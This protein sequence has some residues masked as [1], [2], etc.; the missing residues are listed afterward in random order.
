MI[1][2]F[3]LLKTFNLYSYWHS[4][5]LSS[6]Y[7]STIFRTTFLLIIQNLFIFGYHIFGYL[8]I[9]FVLCPYY[10]GQSNAYTLLNTY[11]EM[12]ERMNH[13]PINSRSLVK[14]DTIFQVRISIWSMVSIQ[15]FV[16][17][18]KI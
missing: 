9:P 17:K 12:S 5:K 2:T 6:I 14:N 16:K 4:S 8:K 18:A 1:F 10:L 7:I 3:H 11:F 13:Q 15:M